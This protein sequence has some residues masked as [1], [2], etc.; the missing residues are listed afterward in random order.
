M[1][2][3]ELENKIY[4]IKTRIEAIM[5]NSEIEYIID[6]DDGTDLGL[7]HYDFAVN[8]SY[9]KT[10]EIVNKLKWIPNVNPYISENYDGYQWTLC[11]SI[12]LTDEIEENNYSKR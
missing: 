9:E 1:N 12:D 4:E 3:I 10:S 2:E 8:E 5:N 6:W 7:W 11:C